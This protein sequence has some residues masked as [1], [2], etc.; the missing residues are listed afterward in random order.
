MSE[1][2]ELK[3]IKQKLNNINKDKI[4]LAISGGVDSI[5]LL[6]ILLSCNIKPILFF[7]DYN[8][9]NNSKKRKEI[10]NRLAIKYD[11]NLVSDKVLIKDKN[12]E[13]K[14]RKIRYDLFNKY[15]NDNN[16]DLILTAHHKDDQL[17]TLYM[18]YEDNADWVSFLGIREKYNKIFRPMLNISKNDIIKYAQNK[19]LCWIDDTSN[20]NLQFRRNKIR[21]K[22][23]PSIL[24]KKPQLV[25]YLFDKNFQSIEKFNLLKIRIDEYLKL[26]I[27]NKKNDYYC[28]SN[29]ITNI[30][31]IIDFKMFYQHIIVNSFNVKV[32]CT[33]S[34]W[35]N[36]YKFI[37]TSTSGS[38]FE[39]NKHI[40]LL[41]DRDYHYIYNN[42][43]ISENNIIIDNLENNWYG[44]KF[45]IN[46]K[47][48]KKF[49]Y[50]D[51]ILLTKDI[52]NNGIKV[53]NWRD[54]DKF[55]NKESKSYKSLKKTFV[56]MKVSV[57]DKITYP[58]VLD[59]NNKIIYIP[60]IYEKYSFVE[61][62]NNLITLS[63]VS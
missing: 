22:T 11:L 29:D 51:S 27:K 4:L 43:F 44:T 16:I 13:S 24:K 2:I 10:C 61:K 34:H 52:Y 55:Y 60:K 19:K 57:F 62:N 45:L 59:S 33:K 15:A 3:H 48:N 1:N 41:N 8:P 31:D 12:F 26:Y 42:E 47:N 7:V 32:N 40:T 58:I 28:I 53:R 38:R 49:N 5:V 9:N 46:D 20:N 23:L 17:E 30:S 35:K 18:K 63:W 56:N 36:L 6:D 25:K 50:I 14:A 39:I 21:L 54:G 37:K